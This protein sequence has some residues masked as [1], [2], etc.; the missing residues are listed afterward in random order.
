[1]FE[2]VER[3]VR[4]T[5]HKPVYETS[6]REQRHIVRKLVTE[7]AEQ[8]QY[9]TVLEPV[10]SHTTRYVD[11]GCFQDIA[12]CKPGPVYNRLA[13]LPSGCAVDP[14][15]GQ[16]VYQRGGLAWVPQQGAARYEVAKVWQPNIVAQQVAQTNYVQ[17]VV[18]HKVP[19]QVQRY[20]DEVVVQ[21]VPV[22]VCRMV[23]EEVV[24]KVPQ[25]VCRQVVERI[26]NKVPVQVCRMVAEEQ[27]RT[28]PVT[29]TRMVTEERSE[30]VP[31]Q[32]CRMVAENQT[33][34]TPRLVEKRTP[35]VQTVRVPRTICLRVPI[36]ECGN[37]IAVGMPLSPQTGT[38]F[39]SPTPAGKEQESA[40]GA[41]TNGN[42]AEAN[43]GATKAPEIE[44]GE[45][46]PGPA[47]E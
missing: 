5:V 9:H 18:A 14:L 29:V 25:T 39:G 17:K 7:C 27:I 38:T 1:V 19:V 36:D 21:K 2:T 31:V 13:W 32:V 22:Q 33:V 23:A 28:I 15:T 45:K 16:S 30:Q 26:E 10:V 42:A 46:V 6:E 35:I 3:E 12:V 43:N 4:Y 11:Q 44:S 8:E 20:V 34:R 24:Q 41:G 47:E 37:P 40:N